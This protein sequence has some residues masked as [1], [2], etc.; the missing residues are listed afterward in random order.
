[1][2][3]N[4]KIEKTQPALSEQ[5]TQPLTTPSADTLSGVPAEI[6][7]AL[8]DAPPEVLEMLKAAPPDARRT[9]QSMMISA[10]GSLRPPVH[11]L[12]E[13]FTPEHIDKFL[14]YSHKD[15]ENNFRLHSSSKWF[16]LTYVALI[17]GMLI[18][19]IVYLT[20]SNKDLLV[21]ILKIFVAFAGGFGGGFGYKSYVDKNK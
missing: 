19:L 8:K 6:V 17:L 10:S 7:D 2:T 18:F 12:F 13:K 11:P 16:H 3:E 1:M 20:P 21:D 5:S 15:D 4:D 14:E 9:I